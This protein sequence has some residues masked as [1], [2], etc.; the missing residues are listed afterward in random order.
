MNE[1]HKISEGILGEDTIDKTNT[2]L[3]LE[4][5]GQYF[6]EAIKDGEVD[7]TALKEEM[8]EFPQ[9][10]SEHYEFTWAGKQAAKK[11]AQADLFGRTLKYKP[12]D[13]LNPDTTENLYIEGDNLEALKLLRRNYQG[14]IKLIYIDPPYNTGEDLLYKDDYL[15]TKEEL[16]RLSGDII[17]EERLQK[18]SKDNAEYH[19]AW[20]NI[21]YPRLLIAKQLLSDD[22]AVFVSI[23]DNEVENLIKVGN[24]VFGD[25]NF[26]NAVTVKTKVGGVSGSSEGKSLKDATEFICIWA[27]NKSEI[28]FNPVYLKTKLFDRIKSY[29]IEGKSWKYTSIVTELSEKVLLKNDEKN[30]MK[31]YGYRILKTQS[32]TSFAK[33]NN[34]AVED[35]YNN[36]ADKIFQTTNAQSSVRQTVIKQTDGYDYPMYGLEYTPIKGKNAGNSIEILYKGEQRRM[37][38]FLSDCVEKVDGEYYYLDKITSLW[39]DIDYNNL[40]KEGNMEFPNGKKPIKLLQRILKLAT[41]KNSFVLDF[42]SGSS[43]MA[44]AVM[45]ENI[46]TDGNRKY[47]MVQLPER[48]YETDSNGVKKAKKS[49]KEAYNQGLET[50]CEIGKERIRRS[51]K[52]LQEEF[53]SAKF[54]MGFKVF[55]VTDTNIKWNTADDNEVLTLADMDNSISDKDR[56]DF[57]KGY[58]DIDVVY[59]VMLRQFD[60]PLST[61]IEKLSSVSDRTYIFADAVVVCLEPEIDEQLI[62]RLAAIE[63]T[64]AK[65]VLRDSA[66]NDDIE[67]KDVSFRRLSALIANHQTEEERK[68]KYNNYTVEFI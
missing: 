41:D 7:F 23:D 4:L 37:M 55:K 52:S 57:N 21:I 60:I 53:N 44:H 54:D 29:E 56:I 51:I 45:R 67:L 17:D 63:P 68:S 24:L 39:D 33:E 2:Q 31:F 49:C 5:V 27:K 47:I 40:T 32:I 65:F 50:I 18:N 59:E 38:M 6:P 30:R 10:S 46:E 36:Y 20:L 19:T 61:P 25:N 3:F 58:T 66:F 48:T 13:S 12:E 28:M 42:F 62:K 43:S 11:E 8:G 9:V 64:P 1:Y 34:I 26:I 14:K 15:L 22:G 16:A 35:V